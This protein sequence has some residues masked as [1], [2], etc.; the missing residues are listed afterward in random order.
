M[1]VSVRDVAEAA[2][3]SV[4]TVSNVLNRPDKVSAETVARVHRAIDLLGF[5][6]NDAARQ[7]RAGRS[8]S[9]GLVVLDMRNPFFTEVARGAEERASTDDLTVLMANSDEK[10][11]REDRHVELFEEQRVF[12]ML[13]TPVYDSVPKLRA[14]RDRGTPTVLVDRESRDGSFASVAVDDLAGG[15]LAA[16]HL[17]DVGRRRLMFV[18]G[19]VSIRQVADRLEGAQGAVAAHGGASLEFVGTRALTVEEGRVAGAQILARPVSARPDAIFAANDLLA[20]GLLQSLVMTASVRV[21]EDIA[22][23]GYDDIDFAAAAVIPLTSVR[24]PAVLMG[25][26]AVEL[27]LAAAESPG[28]PTERVVFGP[29][30]VVRSSTAT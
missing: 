27:L 11:D 3:V 7:L 1:A 4:G 9:I 5:V 19:P 28:G 25:T 6:R 13:V 14:V 24:Q 23:I 8:R 20:L 12:G 10:Q 17:L 29:E 21:P 26:T 18:G 22:L 16:S 30:L 15:T 2:G